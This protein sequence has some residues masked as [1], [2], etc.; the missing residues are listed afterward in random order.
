MSQISA[1]LAAEEFLGNIIEVTTTTFGSHS[2][3]LKKNSV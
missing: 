1:A 2:T 3:P